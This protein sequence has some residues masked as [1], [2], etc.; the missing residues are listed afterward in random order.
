[1]RVEFALRPQFLINTACKTELCNDGD[2]RGS[3]VGRESG[4]GGKQVGERNEGGG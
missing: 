4:Q 3:E 2:G 1:M